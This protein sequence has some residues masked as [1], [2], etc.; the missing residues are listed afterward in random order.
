MQLYVSQR[1]Q[2]CKSGMLKPV[3]PWSTSPI[4]LTR[5]EPSLPA[6]RALAPA[7]GIA[8]R[9]RLARCAG[10][11]AGFGYGAQRL[12][13]HQ[14]AAASGDHLGSPSSAATT[15]AGQARQDR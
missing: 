12:E 6:A 14:K 10:L 7:E 2:R 8:D 15:A 13:P 5:F 4:E 9:D 3:Q 11:R 1:E